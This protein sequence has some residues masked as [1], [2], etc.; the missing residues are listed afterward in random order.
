MTR[1]GH[2]SR[3]MRFPVKSMRG[4]A[5]DS[6]DLGTAGFAG[7]RICALIDRESGKVASAKLPHRW[8]NLLEFKARLLRDGD[9][10]KRP[11][12]EI[13]LPD[14]R[15]VRSD[16]ADIDA[17]LSDVAERAVTLCFS[18][19]DGLE[20]ERARPDEV[21]DRGVEQEVGVDTL[22]LGMGAPQGGFFDFAPVHFITTASLARV[23]SIA[24]IAPVE[25]ERFRPNIIID[26]ADGTPFVENDWVGGT[27]TFGGRV[28][29]EVILATPR[30]AVPTLA[31]GGIAND[32]RLTQRIGTLNKVPIMDMGNLAC[33]GAYGSITHGG[34]VRLGDDVYW[35]R[36]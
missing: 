17:L 22:P 7:D 31:Q 11:L 24:A 28:T 34:P 5:F 2:V 27:L 33:L 13:E 21:A 23:S 9:A 4:E 25:P 8:R 1:I 36:D 20:M 10:G 6:L 18:R 16:R 15:L 19:D 30:C 32:P 14:G 12:I 29:V 35:S 3:L 26:N